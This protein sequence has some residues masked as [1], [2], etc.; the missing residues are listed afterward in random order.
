MSDTQT[1]KG[2]KN[3]TTSPA[4]KMHYGEYK[5]SHTRERNKLKRIL[6]S[7]G[8]AFA[9]RYAKERGVMAAYLKL[10]AK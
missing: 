7:C 5:N 2:G 8:K 10:V 9:E 3:L 6:Q 4:R 1:R